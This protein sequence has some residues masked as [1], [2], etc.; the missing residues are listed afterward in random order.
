MRY[1]TISIGLFTNEDHRGNVSPLVPKNRPF[2]TFCMKFE[3]FED[4]VE[5]F[6]KQEESNKVVCYNV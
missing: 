2:H 4:A 3:D 1:T 5:F 6:D